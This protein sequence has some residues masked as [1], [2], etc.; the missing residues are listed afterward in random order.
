MLMLFIGLAIGG[1]LGAAFMAGFQI[2]RVH[3]RDWE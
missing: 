1:V 3:G 2:N